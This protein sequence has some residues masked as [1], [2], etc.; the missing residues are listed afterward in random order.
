MERAHRA[1]EG[2]RGQLVLPQALG[3][4]LVQ[5]VAGTWPCMELLAAREETKHQERVITEGSSGHLRVGG[6]LPSPHRLQAERAAEIGLMHLN[7]PEPWL[8]G[9]R[10]QDRYY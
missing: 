10:G 2:G 8:V 9:S 7:A 4:N 5:L 1:G 6:S 3:T